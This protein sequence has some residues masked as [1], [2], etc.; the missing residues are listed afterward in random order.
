MLKEFTDKERHLSD[1]EFLKIL[2][3]KYDIEITRNTLARHVANLEED[4]LSVYSVKGQGR[5]MEHTIK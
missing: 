2:K 4:G 5:W 3:N 1:N